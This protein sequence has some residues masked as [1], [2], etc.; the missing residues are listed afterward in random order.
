MYGVGDVV[1]EFI[2]CFKSSVSS[3][4]RTQL[5]QHI[6]K[7]SVVESDGLEFFKFVRIEFLTSSLSAMKTLFSHKKHN[8]IHD[9]L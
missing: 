5:L 8:L 2:S 3:R 6:F 7:L 1:K 9:V 4:L